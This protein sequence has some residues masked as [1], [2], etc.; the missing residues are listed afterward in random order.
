MQILS[1]VH[2]HFPNP[3]SFVMHIHH[4]PLEGPS[5]HDYAARMPSNS[6][7]SQKTPDGY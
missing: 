5:I 7:K 4:Q 3:A 6:R 1:R 2:T